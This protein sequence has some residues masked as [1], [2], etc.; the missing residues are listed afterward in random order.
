MN[1]SGST[2][3]DSSERP[4]RSGSQGPSSGARFFLKTSC[5]LLCLGLLVA[6]ILTASPTWARYPDYWSYTT[7]IVVRETL[8]DGRSSVDEISFEPPCCRSWRAGLSVGYHHDHPWVTRWEVDLSF[9]SVDINQFNLSPGAPVDSVTG[10]G[11]WETVI[12]TV[13][14]YHDFDDDGF[15][16][17]Y[18]GAG[19]GWTYLRAESNGKGIARETRDTDFAPGGEA[20]VGVETSLAESVRL[21]LEYRYTATTEY[22]LT[23]NQGETYR[24]GGLRDHQTLT[25]VNVDF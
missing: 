9:Q 5:F 20:A 4:N 11:D 12:L 22:T 15:L 18:V 10:F 7:G 14:G 2:E 8:D 19:L 13:N 3:A 23:D 6:S 17:P 16:D 25:G 1:T 21:Y 24:T